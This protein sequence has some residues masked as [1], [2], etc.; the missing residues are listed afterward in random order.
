M[1]RPVPTCCPRCDQPIF[2]ATDERGREIKIDAAPN[3]TGSRILSLRDGRILAR[4]A[5]IGAKL[6][7][8]EQLRQAHACA[9]LAHTLRLI[10]GLGPM[11]R[12]LPIGGFVHVEPED[13]GYVLDEE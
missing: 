4:I 5:P 10:K 8:G 9:A 12:I 2:V 3:R 13:E 1:N 11:S 6:A 7:H